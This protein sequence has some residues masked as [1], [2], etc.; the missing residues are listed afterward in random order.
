M[1]D[2]LK[3]KWNLRPQ[4]VPAPLEG[5]SV[6][7]ALRRN[8]WWK[9][10]RS[11]TRNTAEGKCEICLTPEGRMYCHEDWRYD[12][13]SHIAT[14]KRFM[15]ICQNCNGVL[16]IGGG[17]YS[18]SGDLEDDPCMKI[19]GHLMEVNQM[20]VEE[21]CALLVEDNEIYDERSKHEW[22]VEISSRLIEVYPFL[23]D[24]QF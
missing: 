4:R 14:L 21:A 15:W 7:R 22:K 3:Q 13:Q 20:S 16:H 18:W 17:P 9:K 8:K 24:L 12:D 19:I 1:D 23:T 10:I 5:R 11:N 6:Y 2:D